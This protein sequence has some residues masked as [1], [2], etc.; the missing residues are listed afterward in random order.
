MKK[1]KIKIEIEIKNLIVEET[2]HYTEGSGQ[3]WYRFE[4]SVKIDDK[5]EKHKEVEQ[6]WSNQTKASITR[7]LKNGLAFHVALEDVIL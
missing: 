4:Y 7:K 3:G 6:S 5:K 1:N 2:E